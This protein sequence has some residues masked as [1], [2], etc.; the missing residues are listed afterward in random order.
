MRDVAS[1]ADDRGIT[2]QR[3]GV[4]D[5]HLPVM[6]REKAGGNARVVGVFEASVE[7]P[8]GERGTHMSR[9][10]EILSRWS[11]RAVALPEMREMLT[12]VR[13]R[14]DAWAAHI[15]LEFTYFLPKRSPATSLPTQLDYDCW[16]SASCV[17]EE[18]DF[19]VGV[20]VPVITL[21]PCSR[22]ISRYGAHSQR[23]ALRAVVRSRDEKIIWLEDLIPLLEQQGSEQ[24]YPMLKREDERL[25]TERSYENPKFVEDVVRDSVIALRE[26]PDVAWFSVECESFESIHNHSAYARTEWPEQEHPR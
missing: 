19:L 8:H 5:I 14:F 16:F 26:L 20:D 3:V 4:R 15:R 2:I 6:I 23:A 1:E 9:F 11:K 25:I 12:E 18:F 7:L 21:C 22:E 13:A 10:V 24:V 17:D